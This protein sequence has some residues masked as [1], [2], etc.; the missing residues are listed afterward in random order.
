MKNRQEISRRKTGMKFQML[1]LAIF[2]I[3]GA[4][5]AW[6]SSSSCP[7]QNSSSNGCSTI[8]SQFANF[9]SPSGNLTYVNTNVFAYQQTANSPCIYD[10]ASCNN[11]TFPTVLL[12][13]A[14]NKDNVPS[15]TYSVSQLL[16]V[17]KV[18]TFFVGI[19]VNSTGRHA[20]E[21][22]ERFDMYVNGTLT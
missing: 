10:N 16:D 5:S 19:D 13:G 20:T 12:S 1:V 3:V 11:G 22:L 2:T 4:S 8:N 7:N 17:L 14:T 6:A 21:T 18:P 9:T 15:Q